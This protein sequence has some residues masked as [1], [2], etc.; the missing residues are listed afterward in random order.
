MP[1]TCG[2]GWGGAGSGP[3]PFSRH[4]WWL[5]GNDDA[6]TRTE[7]RVDRQLVCHTHPHNGPSE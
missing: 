2:W 1:A 3:L 7:H 6:A 4:C 5:N